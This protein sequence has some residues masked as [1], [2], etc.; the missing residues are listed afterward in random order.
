MQVGEQ[1][2]YGREAIRDRKEKVTLV[3]ILKEVRR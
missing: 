2:E 3:K 1:R